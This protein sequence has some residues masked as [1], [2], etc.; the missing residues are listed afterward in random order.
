MKSP[1]RCAT[2]WKAR[3]RIEV[4]GSEGSAWWDLEDIDRLHVSL[5]D[6]SQPGVTGYTAVHVTEPHHPLVPAWWPAGLGLGWEHSFIH[7]W[8]AFLAEVLGGDKD[9][10]LATFFDGLRAAQLADAIYESDRDK[11]RVLLVS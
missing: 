2:G 7:E 9:A 3:Q 5:R 4:N 1:C 10:H 11:A 6:F 8:R